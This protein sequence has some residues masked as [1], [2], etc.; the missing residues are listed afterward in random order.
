V[1]IEEMEQQLIA[2]IEEI[3]HILAS[4]PHYFSHKPI[5]LKHTALQ[6]NDM[7][8]Q[9][10]TS[11]G[12]LVES[13]SRLQQYSLI[14]RLVALIAELQESA[15]IYNEES[16]KK[17]SRYYFSLPTL[18]YYLKQV[19]QI[20]SELEKMILTARQQNDLPTA[21]DLVDLWNKLETIFRS[22]CK[23]INDLFP[24]LKLK[25]LGL[26]C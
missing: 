13:R 10:I 25:H 22:G 8:V 16:G 3:S 21:V 26:S 15:G 9:A 4:R 5:Q 20:M 11:P 23:I 19:Q 1:S 7:E 12:N 6:L 18:T 14:R 2:R 24:M 17:R